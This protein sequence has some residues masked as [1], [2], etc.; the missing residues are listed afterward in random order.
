MQWGLTKSTCLAAWRMLG[1]AGMKG[2][3]GG[4]SGISIFLIAIVP[5]RAS[6]NQLDFELN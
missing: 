4:Q 2:M 3:T 1:V 6:R 5:D